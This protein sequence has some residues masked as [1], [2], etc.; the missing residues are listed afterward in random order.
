MAEGI[1]QARRRA[2]AALRSILRVRYRG[3]SSTPPPIQQIDSNYVRK[4]FWSQYPESGFP[5][6]VN[7]AVATHR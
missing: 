2:R 4:L 1:E 5:P 3:Q 6:R 7:H